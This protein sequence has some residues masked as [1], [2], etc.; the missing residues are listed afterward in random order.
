MKFDE[1]L[2]G[3]FFYLNDCGEDEIW[4]KV[5]EESAIY[6]PLSNYMARVFK[7]ET[8]KPTIL[9]T[10]KNFK[11]PVNY[12]LNIPYCCDIFEDTDSYDKIEIFVNPEIIY[13]KG[14]FIAWFKYTGYVL[15][16]ENKERIGKRLYLEDYNFI[17]TN[18]EKIL[19][20]LGNE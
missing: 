8:G 18:K 9:S 16:S 2:V 4:L 12:K 11:Y 5:D 19:T 10:T 20:H 14:E 13:Y 1:F 6:V 15:A 17:R 3:E 7:T